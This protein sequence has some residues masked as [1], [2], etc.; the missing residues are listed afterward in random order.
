MNNNTEL[1]IQVK[2]CQDVVFDILKCSDDP[3]KTSEIVTKLIKPWSNHDH[4]HDQTDL[5]HKEL[6]YETT[7]LVNDNL[8]SKYL[9]EGLD[10]DVKPCKSGENLI[11]FCVPDRSCG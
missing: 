1:E 9:K 8:V 11:K 2:S 3:R 7:K 5:I 4:D 10:K 6:S